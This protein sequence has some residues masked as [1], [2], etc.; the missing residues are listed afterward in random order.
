MNSRTITVIP[1]IFGCLLMGF[2]CATNNYKAHFIPRVP[3]PENPSENPIDPQIY[4]VS[5]ERHNEEVRRLESSGHQIIGL[6]EFNTSSSPSGKHLLKQA[7]RVGADV[8]VSSLPSAL[9][10]TIYRIRERRRELPQSV[11]SGGQEPQLDDRLDRSQ[12]ALPAGVGLKPVPKMR[13]S[14]G[15]LRDR[16]LCEL[17]SPWQRSRG[18]TWSLDGRADRV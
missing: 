14:I 4:R 12:G 7:K 17:H 5:M 9:L 8:A 3:L 15:T 13:T 2:G 6:A 10:A 1:A 11:L 16:L 18:R